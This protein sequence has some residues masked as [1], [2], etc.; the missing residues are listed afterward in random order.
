[1][2]ITFVS[3][4]LPVTYNNIVLYSL[5]QS[6]TLE[7]FSIAEYIYYFNLHDIQKNSNYFI[8]DFSDEKILTV[9][10]S[11]NKQMNRILDTSKDMFP[12][13]HFGDRLLSLLLKFCIDI[14]CHTNCNTMISSSCGV[15]ALVNRITV[16]FRTSLVV[17]LIPSGNWLQLQTFRLF[18]LVSY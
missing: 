11:L 10:Q 18:S 1:M 9:Q 15:L 4:N 3:L 16:I 5:V 6:K 17:Y 8:I 12:K 2:F 14:V 7:H 13:I